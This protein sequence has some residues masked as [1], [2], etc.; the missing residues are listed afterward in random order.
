MLALLG[1]GC[2][3]V[4]LFGAGAAVV[5]EAAIPHSLGPPLLFS[6]GPSQ[7]SSCCFNSASD[8]ISLIKISTTAERS[9]G[10]GSPDFALEHL[11]GEPE[12]SQLYRSE[13]DA[14]AIELLEQL[15]AL[16]HR[17]EL[18]VSDA[19]VIE[20]L[21]SEYGVGST[22]HSLVYPVI[23]SLIENR[24]F[25]HGRASKTVQLLNANGVNDAASSDTTWER[26]ESSNRSD[27][28][29]LAQQFRDMRARGHLYPKMLDL[30]SHYFDSVDEDDIFSHLDSRFLRH[31]RFWLISQ[32]VVLR[33]F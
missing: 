33:L 7:P 9:V 2:A 11:V 23:Q 24:T 14:D 25:R 22:V 28:S 12:A 20:Q 27:H 10:G 31:G 4:P 21:T 5:S 13:R 26:I 8:N 17:P 29:A 15:Q 3:L 30:N 16:S 19:I 32:V 18:N 1:A 6:D